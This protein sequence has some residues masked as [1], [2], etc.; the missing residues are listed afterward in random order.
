MNGTPTP[1]DATLRVRFV[2]DSEHEDELA[3]ILTGHQT[4]G[5]SLEIREDEK[6]DVRVFFEIGETA[7]ARELIEA[8]KAIGV[9]RAEIGRQESED[10]LAAYR[11]H[12]RPFAVGNTW[13]IDPHPKNPS[14]APEGRRRL[15]IEPRMAFGTGSH[16]STAL[17]LMEIESVLPEGLSVLDVGTGSGVLAL[18]AQRL[19]ASRV[20]GFDVD[21]EAV[22]VA[23]QIRRD[24]DFPCCPAYFGGTLAALGKS[25][26]D[27]ILCNM[28]SEHFLPIAG[29]LKALLSSR[30]TAV[31]SG[32]LAS[33]SEDVSRQLENAGFQVL[34]TRLL[35]EWI[36]FRVT[37]SSR[38]ANG[39]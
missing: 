14:P 26:F 10:W 3:E 24:Q 4:M 36:A 16:Q 30:G 13:W 5:A 34:S 8:L 29:S 21:L 18:A 9:Q 15:V 20:I 19:G 12:V 1:S 32:I 22:L 37:H 31:F 39:R 11:R 27:L 33:E 7:L 25:S 28:I 2:V 38:P 6:L 23:R 17:V 35:D